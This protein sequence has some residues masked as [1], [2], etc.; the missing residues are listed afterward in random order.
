VWQALYEELAPAGLE[1]VTVALDTNIESAR[2]PAEA[3]HATHP[4]LVDPE[5]RIVE[6]FGI[7]NV[8]FGIWIDERGII[9]RPPEPAPVPP[10]PDAPDRSAFLES[11]PEEQRR[12]IVGMTANAG[13]PTRYFAAVR[14][15]VA[16]GAAS[17]FVL[18]PDEVV[19]RSRP[20]PAAA[21]RA[22]AHYELGQHLH[23][24]GFGQD[25]VAHFQRAHELDPTNWSYQRQARAL[26][27]PAWD[28]AYE[29]DLFTEVG[30]VGPETWRPPLDL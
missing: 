5:F 7:T 4:S 18:T 20:L 24:A 15:W 11:L 2:A 19:A 27:D 21:A 22:A 17:P 13:D 26:A 28:T 12:I 10:P 6:L 8:P 29:R 14:D 30:R 23:L 9:V 3:A 16:N 1:I 25:A